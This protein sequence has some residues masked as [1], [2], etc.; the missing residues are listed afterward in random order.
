M[1]VFP[2]STVL[3]A[4]PSQIWSRTAGCTMQNPKLPYYPAAQA[5]DGAPDSYAR[6]LFGT[7]TVALDLVVARTPNVFGVL[8]HNID[9]GLVCGF[10]ASAAADFSG[11]LLDRGAAARRPNFWLDLRGF[12]TAACRGPRPRCDR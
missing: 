7:D 4:P 9:W 1:P 10:Q 6:S 5:V 8:A 12:P 3:I 2:S 11:L